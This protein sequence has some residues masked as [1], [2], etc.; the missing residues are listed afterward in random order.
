VEYYWGGIEF[1]VNSRKQESVRTVTAW[2][3]LLA[4]ALLYAPLA[5][6]ALLA[7]GLDCCVGGFCKIPEH[8]HHKSQPAASQDTAPMDCGHE[9]SGMKSCSMSCCKDP[10]RPALIP[11]SF[12]LRPA[13]FALAVG[14]VFALVQPA[15]SLELSRFLK[16]LSP[17]PRFASP[18][19]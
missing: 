6:A 14:E 9:M 5:G 10:T 16:P 7:H 18:V 4:V 19:L 1:S 15:S 17:P 13:N 2:L 3:C 12:L 11:G 8:H